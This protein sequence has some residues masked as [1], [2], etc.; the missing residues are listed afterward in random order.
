LTAKVAEGAQALRVGMPGVE[1]TEGG[2]ECGLLRDES[3]LTEVHVFEGQVGA[4][5]T[6]RQG[7]PLPGQRLVEKVAARVDVSRQTI[8]PVPLNESAFARLRPEV[9]VTDVAVRGGQYSDRNF[10]TSPLLM[11]KNSIPD[12]CWETYLRFDLAGIKAAVSQARVRLVPVHVGQPFENAVALV[13]DPAW[14]ETTLTWD[15]RP[16]SGPAFASWTVRQ[17]EPV[18]FDVTRLVQEALAG[19][20]KLSLRLFAPRYQRGK[21]WVQYGSRKGDPQARPQ[22]LLSTVP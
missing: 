7:L 10:G 14:G 18:E 4:D 21:R 17:G 16:A 3:G 11:V 5:P 22:L 13:P 1:V 19:T 8:T 12:Y 9:R 2:G 15:D 20:K 6:D